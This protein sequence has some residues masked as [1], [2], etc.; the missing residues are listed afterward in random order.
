MS[1][2]F[3]HRFYTKV[4][5]TFSILF[6]ITPFILNAVIRYPK[7]TVLFVIS[8]TFIVLFYDKQWAISYQIKKTMLDRNLFLYPILPSIV[9]YFFGFAAAI[10]ESKW[11]KKYSSRNLAITIF[12]ILIAHTILVVCTDWYSE[13]VRNRQYF[14]IVEAISAYLSLLIVKYL[15]THNS[16]K[17][18][19]SSYQILCIGIYSL[20]FYLMSN[21]ILGLLHITAENSPMVRVLGLFGTGTLAYIFAFWRFGNSFRLLRIQKI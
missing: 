9:V 19:L 10:Y 8:A 5:F 15:L 21:L 17:R 12:A 2:I 4:L 18:F 7:A 13:I 3:D 20:H 1:F 6:F 16:L 14:I 11:G